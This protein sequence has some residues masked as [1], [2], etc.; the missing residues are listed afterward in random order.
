MASGTHLIGMYLIGVYQY[1]TGVYLTDVHLMGVHLMG[2]YLMDVHLTDVHLTGVYLVGIHLMDVYFMGVYLMGVYL[3]GVHLTGVHLI[4]VH[5]TGVQPEKSTCYRPRLRGLLKEAPEILC[6]GLL[7]HSMT[8]RSKQWSK[9][10]AMAEF[11]HFTY[12]GIT[13]CRKRSVPK[14]RNI[15]TILSGIGSRSTDSILAMEF[16]VRNVAPTVVLP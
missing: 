10:L 8:T 3:M 5:L 13:S 16:R 15:Q 1:F 7:Y 2:M 9:R 6:C 12:R 11:V 4:N 14:I